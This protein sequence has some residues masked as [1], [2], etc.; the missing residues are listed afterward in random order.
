MPSNDNQ[1]AFSLE[2]L[3]LLAEQPRSRNELGDLLTEFLE[4]RNQSSGDILQ[5]LTRA[6]AKLR[7]CGF[8]ISSAPNR[9]YQLIESNFPIILS[10]QQKE[11]LSLGI[12]LLSRL[13]FSAQAERI[14]RLVHFSEVELSTE[15]KVDFNP[16]V[17]YSSEKISEIIEELQQRIEK[18]CRFSICY[19][20][21]KGDERLWDLDRSELRLHNGVLYLFSVVPNLPSLQDKIRADLDKNYLFQIS[22]I[23]N[24][25]AASNTRWFY[26]F[27]KI[28]IRYR[29]I[30]PLANYKPRR[31][32]EQVIERNLEK[33]FVVIETTEDYLFWFRQRILQYGANAQILEPEWLVKD[34]VNEIQV[35]YTNYAHQF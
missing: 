10:S 22:R 34:I 3:R 1:L 14:A 5:K 2:I 32:H 9:P 33:R 17:D 13:G 20:S 7:T 25:N 15:L 18:Q 26:D 27:S 12:Y 4:S 28:T 6:I 23:K 35:A 16:P 24:V 31:K 11:A 8:E 29:L 19:T 30:G 21:S